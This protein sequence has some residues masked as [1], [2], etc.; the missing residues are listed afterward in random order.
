[1]SGPRVF[2]AHA[3]LIRLW[4]HCVSRSPVFPAHAGLIRDFARKGR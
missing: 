1:M 3:G 2:P 4:Q